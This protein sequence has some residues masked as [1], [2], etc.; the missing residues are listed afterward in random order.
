VKKRR[1]ARGVELLTPCVRQMDERLRTCDWWYGAWS[2][3]DVYFYW[4]YTTAEDGQ[5]VLSLYPIST[6]TV[7][8]K[9]DLQTVLLPIGQGIELTV[10]W[11]A[12]NGKL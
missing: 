3:I 5:S 7:R 8:A 10:K 9:A 12:G 11:S 2:I 1:Y 6:A 4:A